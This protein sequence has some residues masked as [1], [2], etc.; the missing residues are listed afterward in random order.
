MGK[1]TASLLFFLFGLFWAC[2]VF[3][4][5]HTGVHCCSVFSFFGGGCG[6]EGGGVGG[7]WWFMGHVGNTWSGHWNIR[8]S[9]WVLGSSKDGDGALREGHVHGLENAKWRKGK[10]VDTQLIPRISSCKQHKTRKWMNV[11]TKC[12]PFTRSAT[13]LCDQE[14]IPASLCW[15]YKSKFRSR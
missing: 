13:Y 12:L 4:N 2:L 15:H 5:L 9:L 10:S 6:D 3:R 14:T 11:I 8:M 1:K 7:C